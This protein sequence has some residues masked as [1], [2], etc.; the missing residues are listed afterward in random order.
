M[1]VVITI[2]ALDLNMYLLWV[3]F[4]TRTILRIFLSF[5]YKNIFQKKC[6]HMADHFRGEGLTENVHYSITVAH[7]PASQFATVHGPLSTVGR[8]G[9]LLCANILWFYLI[10]ILINTFQYNMSVYF[11]KIHNLNNLMGL[12]L[13]IM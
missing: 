9:N 4:N 1:R 10:C 12:S 7:V 11:A 13:C 2:R 5:S 8:L 6:Q 3:C